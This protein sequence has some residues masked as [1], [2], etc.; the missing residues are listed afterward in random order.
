[1]TTMQFRQDC[2][3]RLQK[4]TFDVLIIG[5]GINGSSSAAA[6][7]AHGYKVALVEKGDFAS[8]TSQESSNMIWGGIKYLESLE[9]GLVNS[10]CH[11][12]NALMRNY[13]SSIREVRFIFNVQRHS[14][15]N[16]RIFLF[17]GTWIY[18]LLGR[19]FTRTPNWLS[20]KKIRQKYPAVNT[21]NSSGGV[22]YSDAILL[23]NDARFTFQF[24]KNA[25]KQDAVALNYTEA[26]TS[27]QTTD[28]CWNTTIKDHCS[29]SSY[30]IK[31]KCL[32]N[33][34][35]PFADLINQKN[36][37]QT[38]H[39]L[40]FSKGVHLI[41]PKITECN[42]VLTFY[43][44]DGRFFFVL[45]MGH[46][47]CIG[48]TDTPTENIQSVVE[49]DDR[50]YILSHINRYL[51]LSTR[52][53]Q[54]DIIAE[55][56]GVRPL[57]SLKG[58]VASGNWL[59][60][61]R[62]HIIECDKAKRHISIF[63]GKLTDCLNIGEEIVAEIQNI[64]GEHKHNDEKWFGEPELLEKKSF[65]DYST[66]VLN[67][68]PETIADKDAL[69]S[70]LWRRYGL[71]AT[72]IM[73]NIEKKSELAEELVK[74]TKYLR[75]E[76]YYAR[77][78]EMIIKLEDLLRRRSKIALLQSKDKLANDPGVIEL[79]HILFGD[80]AKKEYQEYFGKLS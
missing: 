56:C 16:S 9:F 43:S 32:I 36:Q 51:N 76:A 15:K 19:C 24:I 25:W 40:N 42:D 14:F 8:L 23:D 62:K 50:A 57:V 33:A 41:V 31:S 28:G 10:L 30:Q 66:K 11:S 72:I 37:I 18:W 38:T 46:R 78:N 48:T 77:E 26:Y 4:S 44:D 63:G 53:T 22:E 70:R 68:C 1:M 52:L 59:E 67:Q 54:K 29:G 12:R 21:I 71:D 5:G 47:S 45:P 80:H 60:Q 64:I 58:K 74:E 27:T 6:L 17:F 55:R 39:Q 69:I 34:C 7:S 3:D 73:Q 61:S 20:K 65:W 75:A 35:G 79:C 13:P 49:D 2:L